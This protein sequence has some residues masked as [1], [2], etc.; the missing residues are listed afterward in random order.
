MRKLQ[1]VAVALLVC[2]SVAIAQSKVDTKWHCP[3][4][5]GGT[6]LDV[7]DM[8]DHSYWIGQGTC[9]ATSSEGTIKEKNGQFTEF[10]ENWKASFSFHG[11][12]NATADNGDKVFYSY[13]GNGSTDA[14][15]PQA[16]KWKIVGG[17]GKYKAAKGSGS[18]S[19]KPA[20]DSSVDWECT[21]TSSMGA[22]K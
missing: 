13:E 21:G 19:G 5:E 12:F 3:K 1:L 20:A 22:S 15:K 8:P 2:G 9:T 17:T 18:C 7:G 16:N 14:T 10:H 6:K 11:R 4:P